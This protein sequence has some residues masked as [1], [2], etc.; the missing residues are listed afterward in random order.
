MRGIRKSGFCVESAAEQLA[1]RRSG[2]RCA[3]SA[4][5]DDAADQAATQIAAFGQR[6]RMN[7]E[8]IHAARCAQPISESLICSANITSQLRRIL[9]ATHRRDVEPFVRLVTDE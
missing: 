5:R 9:V 6:F 4:Q 8:P 1:G 2:A 7:L 3:A